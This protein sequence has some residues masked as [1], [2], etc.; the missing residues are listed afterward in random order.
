[1]DARLPKRAPKPKPPAHKRA[2]LPAL[3]KTQLRPLRCDGV[4]EPIKGKDPL[5]PPALK[6][7]AVKKAPLRKG[8]TPVQ[9]DS[10]K[11]QMRPALREGVLEPIKKRVTWDLPLLV[12]SSAAGN[13]APL[14]KGKTPVQPDSTKTQLRPP[15]L[16][17]VLEPIKGKDP[18][19]PPALKSAAVKKAPLR[20]GKSP[21][22][23][24]STKTPPRLAGD[25]EPIKKLALKSAAVK[26]APLPKEKTPVLPDF[27]TTPQR[28]PSLAA[29]L[30]QKKQ[31]VQTEKYRWCDGQRLATADALSV[32]RKHLTP[33][34]QREILQYKEVWYLGIAAEK[35]QQK[36]PLS[37]GYD[38]RKGHYK[39]VIKDH[40]AYRYEVLEVMGQGTFGRVLKC[41]DHKTKQLV[42]MKVIANDQRFKDEAKAEVEILEL[43]QK[44]DEDGLANVVHMKEYFQFRDHVCITFDLM[45]KSLLEV[46]KQ[47]EYR[48]LGASQVRSHAISLVQSL[49]FLSRTDII[50]CDLKPENILVS[51]G[52]PAVIK[53]ADFG[54]SLR[55]HHNTIPIAQT[56]AYMSPEVILTK[57]F[58][59]AIDMWSLGCILAELKTGQILFNVLDEYEL[60]LEMTKLLGVPPKHM[61]K[62]TRLQGFLSGQ[63]NSRDM[64]KAGLSVALNTE[65]PLLLDFVQNC[66]EYEP[67]KRMTPDEARHHP[68]IL[69]HFQSPSSSEDSSPHQSTN[70]EHMVD[71]TSATAPSTSGPGPRPVGARDSR[72]EGGAK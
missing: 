13:K 51:E 67:A 17:G 6:S 40:I 53:V 5:P 47:R 35:I 29:T 31:R 60:V 69:M 33:F 16:A 4:L 52:D 41:R 20:N 3:T 42:A 61:L 26:K 30:D 57:V 71:S 43:L 9:P 37:H 7:A 27:D 46:L 12:L 24:D 55:E 21:V 64:T 2:V 22:Q 66:L 36:C 8:K 65:D 32:F 23:P 10:T 34:E 14:Q 1:M 28:A 50:H 70:W 54:S 72:R 11:T 45:G 68:W 48:G 56:M 15:R 19:P 59:K 38:D 44:N 58:T 49:Q 62:K 18:L 39:M 63:R 25:L